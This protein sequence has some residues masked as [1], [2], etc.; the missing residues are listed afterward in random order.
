MSEERT[1]FI[2]LKVAFEF[3]GDDLPCEETLLTP[4]KSFAKNHIKGYKNTTRI[5]VM[6]SK[7]CEAGYGDPE[8]EET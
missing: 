7:I 1:Y 5:V 3:E 6:N 2:D 4:I 8:T